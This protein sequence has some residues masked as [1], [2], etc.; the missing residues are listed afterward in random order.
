[1]KYFSS[2]C[3]LAALLIAVPAFGQRDYK[4][5]YVITNTFD[6]IYGKIDLKSNFSNSRVCDFLKEEEQRPVSLF[7]KDIYGYRVENDKYYISR[8]IRLNDDTV[9]VFLEYLIDGIVDLYYYKGVDDEFYFIQK[10][11]IMYHISNED[12]VILKDEGVSTLVP[13]ITKTNQYIGVLSYLFQ[14]SPAIVSEV[15]NTPFDYKSLVTLTEN[16]HNSICSDYECIDFTK[17]TDLKL[18]LELHAGIIYS[19]MGMRTSG[20]YAYDL[21]PSFGLNL[22]I[23]PFRSLYLW[24]FVF[25]VEYSYND[26]SEDFF[27]TYFWENGENVRIKTDYSIVRIPMVIEYSFPGKKIQPYISLGYDN[28]FILNSGYS[29]RIIYSY[30]YYPEPVIGPETANVMRKYNSGFSGG[31]GMKCNL[32]R[33][34]YLYLRAEY[35]YRTPVVKISGSILDY[36]RVNSIKVDVGYGFALKK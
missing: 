35:E 17:S 3:L 18:F 34:S 4:P 19:V 30:P 12:K 28:A 15:R 27:M 26:F 8:D 31:I 23:K 33:G 25:G 14:D 5:G 11:G 29:A 7:P 36:Y 6:T 32:N 1:M 16:Y 2:I 20:D 21:H 22:R 13:Y 24:N 10:E 9:S